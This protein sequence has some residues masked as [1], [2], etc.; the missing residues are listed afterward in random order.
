M[1]FCNRFFIRVKGGSWLGVRFSLA[2]LL[3]LATACGQ[4][5]ARRESAALDHNNRGNDLLR[6]GQLDDAITE[7]RKAIELAPNME[8]AKRN[9]EAVL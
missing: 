2:T 7:D 5:R 4:G 8:A 1:V 9:L 6:E 3:M